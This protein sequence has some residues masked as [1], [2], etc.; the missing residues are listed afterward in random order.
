MPADRFRLAGIILTAL[1]L[2]ACA[3]LSQPVDSEAGYSVR[4]VF[5]ATTRNDTG[6]ANLNTRF[7][8]IRSAVTYGQHQVA[9]PSEYPKAH[10]ASFIH[11]N[12]T[13]KRNPDKHVTL[14]NTTVQN[15]SE[16]FFGLEAGV[17][18]PEEPVLVF[19]HGFNTPFERAARIAAKISYDLDLNNPVTLFAW[20]SHDRPSTYPADEDNL[21]WSQPFITGFYDDLMTH[22]PEQD[23]IFLGHSMGTRA[24]TDGLIEL[25]EQRPQV[26]QR[27][28]GVAFAAP[29]I[30]A[31]I[32]RR[33][34]APELIRH[35]LP[36][37]LYASRRD[38]AIY[39]S[40]QLH[41]YPRAG[42]A[43]E[44][45]VVIPGIDTIDASQAEAEML[46][47]EYFY[48]GSHTIRDIYQWLI[49]GQP[50]SKRQ[51]L[52]S[53]FHEDGRYWQLLPELMPDN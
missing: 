1:L 37:T 53:I 29:D 26:R 41:K 12:M 30:D 27:I 9:V 46:G 15:T 2:S 45:I 3:Q 25:L 51:H 18:H 42:Y 24:M 19:I 10:S 31:A 43:G 6:K 4:P 39:A 8:S 32:F 50:A 48:Q 44:D 7:G 14:L 40:N 20:P 28:T 5:F 23:F 17:T 47:H 36:I 11:W 16:F 38:L 21:S 13:L 34:L 49:E 33:D 22:L 35:K 52:V